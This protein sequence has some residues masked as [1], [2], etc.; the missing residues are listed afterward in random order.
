MSDK[1]AEIFWK[2]AKTYCPDAKMLADMSDGDHD[3]EAGFYM[4]SKTLCP[5]VL[6]E[7][8][9]YDYEPDFNILMSEE[10]KE[11]IAEWYYQSIKKC[12]E[13]YNKTYNNVN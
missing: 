10:G 13:L 3:Y 1:Y 12:I 4:V 5:A 7:S 6:V 2:E 9:F 8:Y 11:Q